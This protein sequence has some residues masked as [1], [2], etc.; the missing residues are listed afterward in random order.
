MRVRI[1]YFAATRDLL[2]RAEEELDLPPEIGTLRAFLAHLEI[3][4]PALAGRLETV[5]VA[6]NETFASLD[7][8]LSEGDVLALIPPVAGG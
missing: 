1:L 7:Q 2:G 5:R 8:R 4:H 3:L 6:Q